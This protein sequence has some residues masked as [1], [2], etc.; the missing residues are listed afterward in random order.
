MKIDKAKIK[1][2]LQQELKKVHK[3]RL[4]EAEKSKISKQLTEDFE[5]IE[6]K[7]QT[8]D[9]EKVFRAALE[10]FGASSPES[11]ADE[12]KKEFFD[13]V[14]SQWISQKEQQGLH[15]SES[16]KTYFHKA[17]EK[18]GV[19]SPK[20]LPADKKKEFYNYVDANWKAE[21]EKLEETVAPK[22]MAKLDKIKN[23]LGAEKALEELV[24]KLDT[25][26]FNN[27]ADLIIQD[28]EIEYDLEEGIGTSFTIRKGK[29]VKPC[30]KKSKYK[31]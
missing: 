23:V 21:D 12:K 6:E 7:K 5:P 24:R 20:D 22:D 18:Y 9:Y 11:I 26:I 10:K 29:N 1:E 17:L 31:K 2:R 28:Y 14:D 27:A 15:E 8:G 3:I 19:N 13:Y 25:Q 30:T 16:Y 4:L